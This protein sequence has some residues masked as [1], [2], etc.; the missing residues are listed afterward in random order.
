MIRS[1]KGSGILKPA[2][3]DPEWDGISSSCHPT[4]QC[5]GRDKESY[6]RPKPSFRGRKRARKFEKREVGASWP[7]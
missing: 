1:L 5:L 4:I 3:E 2:A 6:A 7:L